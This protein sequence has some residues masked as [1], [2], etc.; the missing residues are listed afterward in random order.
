MKDARLVLHVGYPK[1]GTTTLQR[2]VFPRHTDIDYLGKTIPDYAYC[3]EGLGQALQDLTTST[4]WRWTG[5]DDLKRIVDAAMA[6]TR[7]PLVLLS[8]EN[9]VHPASVSPSLV[10]HRLARLF[11]AA[12]ILITLRSQL[13]V[14]ESFYRNHG[15]FSAYLY[16]AINEEER[17]TPP[18]EPDVWLDLNFRAPHKNILGVLDFDAC[19]R[20]YEEL[21]GADRVHLAFVEELAAAPARYASRL[22]DALQVQGEEFAALL[23][24]HRDNVGLSASEFERR[25]L[26][27]KAESGAG[28]G[29]GPV[30][31]KAEEVAHKVEFGEDWRRRIAERFAPGNA[32]LA[33]RR[34]IDLAALGY[35]L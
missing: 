13:G 23:G 19:I 5:G 1:T 2:R 21:F 14:L 10:A 34:G 12:E 9:L 18:F 15:A 7:K 22:A 30:A 27:S 8:S 24:G 17:V 16:L 35:P 31:R 25:R 32:R 26:Q 29:A 11:P 3:R 4:E 33:A 20:E 28:G 6:E